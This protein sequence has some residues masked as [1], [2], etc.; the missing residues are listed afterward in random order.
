MLFALNNKHFKSCSPDNKKIRSKTDL[1]LYLVKNQSDLD[2]NDFDFSVRGRA[3][4]PLKRPSQRAPRPKRPKKE[5]SKLV[6]QSAPKPKP[7]KVKKTS[8]AS[9]AVNASNSQSQNQAS[10]SGPKLIVK[11]NFPIARLKRTA[12]MKSKKTNKKKVARQDSQTS[13]TSEHSHHSHSSATNVIQP[14]EY[15]EELSNGEA[16]LTN[17]LDFDENDII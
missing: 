6:T 12:S 14:F 4:T 5:P 11:F 9:S 2:P 13:Q 3:N 1:M 7:T 16:R 17:G 15:H 10:S 8:K